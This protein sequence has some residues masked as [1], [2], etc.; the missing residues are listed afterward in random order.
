MI[1]LR[2]TGKL[3]GAE[4]A[5]ESLFETVFSRQHIR[6]GKSATFE[7]HGIQWHLLASQTLGF[8]SL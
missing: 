6:R 5:L 4:Q 2:M 7:F 8:W 3:R 1:E